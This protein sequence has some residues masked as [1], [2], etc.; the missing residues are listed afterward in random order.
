MDSSQNIYSSSINSK[1]SI[2]TSTQ[3][4][5]K[6]NQELQIIV[7]FLDPTSINGLVFNEKTLKEM[8][9]IIERISKS[10]AAAKKLY[11]KM[12]NP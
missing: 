7:G 4:S 10:K 3:N 8:R 1:K 6:V 9:G 12:N 11:N 5:K 2:D